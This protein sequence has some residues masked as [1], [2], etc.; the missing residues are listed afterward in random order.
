MTNA[1][2][3]ILEYGNKILETNSDD[4]DRKYPYYFQHTERCI[5]V[6][7]LASRLNR[8]NID[9]VLDVG[10]TF[11]SHDYLRFLLNWRKRGGA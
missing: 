10:F 3:E 6:P 1:E 8:Y 5:E 9:T 11:A 2:K 7:W 4:F